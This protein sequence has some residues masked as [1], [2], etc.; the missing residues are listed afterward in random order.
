MPQNFGDF[1]DLDVYTSTPSD[2]Q[3][4]RDVTKWSDE[5]GC[6]GM[7]VYTDNRSPDPWV[8]A[9]YIINQTK[10][11]APLI[12]VQ[13]IYMHPYAAA[14]K[15][16][17]IARLYS[18]AVDL[19]FVAGG[20]PFDMAALDDRLEHDAR[21]ERLSEYGSI[22]LKLLRGQRVT[23]HG[24]YYKVAGLHLNDPLEESLLPRVTVAGSSPAGRKC[25]ASLSAV[26]VMY[27]EPV[28]N[29]GG[30]ERLPESVKVGPAGIRIGILARD[31]SDAA[32]KAAEAWLPGEA[33]NSFVHESILVATDSY[34]L[35]QLTQLSTDYVKLRR[36]VY[37]LGPFNRGE[38]FCPYLVG[39]YEDVA[40]Y[41]SRYI[42]A[43]VK[44]IIL[45]CPRADHDLF[46]A[47][48]ALDRAVGHYCI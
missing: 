18:R 4:L 7:L 44:V 15:I 25:A 17:A 16:S 22:L 31:T 47:Y 19:N 11:L 37:W 32:W 42:L 41:M 9:Q 48:T 3:L 14:Q 46:H 21:Y 23:L 34:W 24:R 13:P 2:V 6:R 38:S 8:L 1:R 26:P 30:Q 33:R 12:A 40:M 20:F 43:G 29:S 5:Y 27:P 28:V 45:D 39:S 36:D 35:R 10:A